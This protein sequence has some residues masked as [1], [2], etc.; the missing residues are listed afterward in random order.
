VADVG[1]SELLAACRDGRVLDCARDGI[2]RALDGGLI[3]RCCLAGPEVDPRGLRLRNAVISGAVDLAGCDVPFPLRFEGCSFDAAPV[4]DGARLEELALTGCARLPGLLGNGLRV[5]R[6]LDL[7]RSALTGA[8]STSASMSKRSAIWLCESDIG[9]RLLCIGTS[10]LADGERSLQADRM[11]VAGAVRLA[12]GFTATG[13]VRLVGARIDGSLDLSGARITSP[14][15]LAINLS[16]AVIDGSVFLMR[17]EAGHSPVIKGRVDLGSTRIAGQLL[18]RDARIEGRSGVP[19]GSAYSQ[20]RAGTVAVCAPR[21]TVG[22]EVT[23]EGQCEVFGTLDLSMSEMSSLVIGRDCSLHGLGGPALDLA[24]ADL[25]SNL[26]LDGT[27]VEGTVGLRGARIRGNVSL[28][29]ARLSVRGEAWAVAA[30]GVSVDGDVLLQEMQ[31]TGG[32]VEL[33]G[34]TVRGN[35]S[36]TGAKLVNPRGYTLSLHHAAVRGSVMLAGL[37]SRGLAVL[38]R[39]VIDGRLVCAGAVFT[40]RGPADHNKEGHAI[41]AVS[42]TVRGGMDLRWATVSPSLDFTNT[43]TTYLT[44]DPGTWPRRFTISG[45]TYDRFGQAEGT[46]VAWPDHVARI[47][48]LRRQAAFDAGAYEQAAAVFRQ[49]GHVSEAEDVLIEK[50]RQA[51]AVDAPWPSPRRVRDA[52]YGATVGYGYRPARVLW[53]IAALLILVGASL[54]APAARATLR[55]SD[56][57]GDVYSTSGLIRVGLAPAVR[58]RGGG[59]RADSCGDGQ[60]RCFSPALY[61]IDTVIP[62]ISLDQRTTW[63]P[64]PHL[65][66]GSLMQWWL[67]I[68]TMLGWLLS[69]I[70]VLSLARLARA[71]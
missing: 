23:L 58:H 62:L 65:P 46:A 61:A 64:D 66:G 27:P 3:R 18:I 71:T 35:V 17:R 43:A 59:P 9:G 49:Q 50:R 4:L 16:D 51:G 42:A 52:I 63:Y 20:S 25:R 13:E 11:H 39:A 24:S 26:A 47:A 40:S 28:Q 8:H 5:R 6:D 45:F 34:A 60:V 14:T 41:K 19:A 2:P 68:A 69:S 29:Q 48:W 1:E 31:V 15:G 7:S 21:L 30:Q 32:P 56:A 44:D 54:Q 55:A 37:E 36:A 67:N 12:D 22:G 33:R 70:F 38:S 10:V 57:A 53:L